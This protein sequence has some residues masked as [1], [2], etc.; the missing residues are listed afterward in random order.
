MNTE[1]RIQKQ[2]DFLYGKETSQKIWIELKRR[3]QNFK[4]ENSIL[5]VRDCELSEKDIVLITYSDQFREEKTAPLKS[6][7]K[8]LQGHLL[9][10]INSVHILPF[11]PYSSD[12]GFS[13]IDFRQ[14]DPKLG[15]W[16]NIRDLANS[17]RLMIDLVIN[18]ISS[19]SDW[20]Q[21]FL[22]GDKKYE[23]FFI[24]V[25]PESDLSKVVRPR[26]LPLLTKVQTSAG[27][28]YVWTTFSTDQI[29]LNYENSDLKVSKQI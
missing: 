19:H 11:F 23:N 18:H 28:K 25:P 26:A 17:F 1:N 16:H 7:D 15:N 12:D 24:T 22:K 3:L 2:L 29:D 21:K 20:F 8:F 13:V 6:L 9:G 4:T 27:E 10:A 14:V 5:S